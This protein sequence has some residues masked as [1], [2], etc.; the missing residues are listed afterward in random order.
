M[1]LK[2]KKLCHFFNRLCQETKFKGDWCCYQFYADNDIRSKM[3]YIW[4]RRP[5]HRANLSSMTTVRRVKC[6]EQKPNCN[7]C[8]ST[9][10]KV[11][12]FTV[13]FL[14]FQLTNHY[15]VRWVQRRQITR[16]ATASKERINERIKRPRPPPNRTSLGNRRHRRR[17]EKLRVLQEPDSLRTLRIL[18][19]RVLGKDRLTS[20][21]L[22]T[23]C[24]ACGTGPKFTPRTVW[25]G[26]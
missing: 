25:S 26:W 3:I 23:S 7:R 8:T 14:G 17:K 20:R 4:L 12:R 10:R 13:N 5:G 15:L 18:R 11:T 19:L 6:D 24:T 16:R 21:A 2:Q 1:S 9:G 22:W